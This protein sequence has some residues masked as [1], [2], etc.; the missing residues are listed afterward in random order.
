[1]HPQAGKTSTNAVQACWINFAVL[2]PHWETAEK[3]K[4]WMPL[5]AAIRYL[6][7]LGIRHHR[8]SATARSWGP[9][10]KPGHEQ[11]C[12]LRLPSCKYDENNL[13]SGNCRTKTSFSEEQELIQ[14][15]AGW[16]NKVCHRNWELCSPTAQQA[17]QGLI[18][19]IPSAAILKIDPYEA[20]TQYCHSRRE[21]CMCTHICNYHD[22]CVTIISIQTSCQGKGCLWLELM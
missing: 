1:M 8:L 18:N 4:A 6:F 11:C 13:K 20:A 5:P 10:Q 14:D 7:L 3:S 15:A 22:F 16:Q 21:K 19:Q 9:F 17:V 12:C 2:Q